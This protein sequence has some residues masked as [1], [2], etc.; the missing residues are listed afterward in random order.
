MTFPPELAVVPSIAG[1]FFR[2]AVRSAV[3]PATLARFAPP[4][5][6]RVGLDGFLALGALVGTVGWAGTALLTARP[7]LVGDPVLVS[8]VLWAVLVAVM[9]GVGVFG[10]P[11][12][13]RFSRPMLVWGPV[14]ALATLATLLALFG[15]LPEATPLV[16]WGLAGLVGYAAS[17]YWTAGVQ[18]RTYAVAA[19]FEAQTLAAVTP[20]APAHTYL[21]LG[22][23]HAVPLAVV[24]TT[25]H[26]LA[27][28]AVGVA[29]LVVLLAGLV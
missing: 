24:A 23:C 13:V 7:G 19:F 15:P 20:L 6:G 17:A 11:D 9:V 16:A 10:T 5:L 3:T 22:V 28:Y 29:W 2:P 1:S 21:L 27:P 8:V 4:T 25:R 12:A 14:N 18:R 26:R